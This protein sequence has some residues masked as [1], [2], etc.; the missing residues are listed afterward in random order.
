MIFL[1]KKIFLLIYVRIYKKAEKKISEKPWEKKTDKQ[2]KAGKRRQRMKICLKNV[3]YQ[4]KSRGENTPIYALKNISLTI[5]QG[6]Y[7]ALIGRTG[8]GKSTL[9][10]ILNGLIIPGEGQYFLNE[11]N[12]HE[13][14]FPLQ[15]MRR[16]VGLC[17]QYPEYQLFEETVL[18]D[19]SFGPKNMGLSD[20]EAEKRARKAMAE[21]GLPKELEAVSP[22]SLSGGQKRRVALAGILAMEPEC[23]ILDEP[24]AGLDEPGRNM[25]FHILKKLNEE[26]KTTILLVSHD[27]D[28][29]AENAKR[30]IVLEDGQIALDD[31]TDKV[32]SDRHALTKAG[33]KPPQTLQFY[34]YL[35]EKI[36]FAEEGQAPITVEKLAECILK[37]KKEA[38]ESNDT[39]NDIGTIL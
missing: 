13:K 17:F 16:K 32:F 6:E 31:T 12:V 11:K 30:V 1:L 39:G 22:F 10:Q 7:I 19:I 8:S 5:E 2:Q 25:L 36:S 4:Y 15:E 33:L 21:M 28:D 14:D 18:K 34:F 29:V 35:K 24:V 38:E 23:L 27:M 9:L 37:Q 3:G 20:E 26:R